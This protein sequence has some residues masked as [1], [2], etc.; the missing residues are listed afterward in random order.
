[1]TYAVVK[2]LLFKEYYKLSHCKS[3][4]YRPTLDKRQK[5]RTIRQEEGQDD[6]LAIK[7]GTACYLY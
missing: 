1:M 2:P 3:F 7:A 6:P 4:A 5:E